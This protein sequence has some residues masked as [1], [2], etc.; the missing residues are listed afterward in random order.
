MIAFKYSAQRQN[1]TQRI[2]ITTTTIL[3]PFI[4]LEMTC[5]TANISQQKTCYCIIF[6]YLFSFITKPSSFLPISPIIKHLILRSLNC[7]NCIHTRS[8]NIYTSQSLGICVLCMFDL[9]LSISSRSS[10]RSIFPIVRTLLGSINLLIAIL[11]CVYVLYANNRLSRVIIFFLYF[12]LA[13]N[14]M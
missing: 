8:T 1:D 12:M 3:L 5:K 14:C 7:V 10:N 6:T 13:V 4:Q 9:H 11:S 2:E